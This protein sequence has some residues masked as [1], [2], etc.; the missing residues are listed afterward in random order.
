VGP[1]R[2]P[3]PTS[4]AADPPEDWEGGLQG[5]ENDENRAKAALGR[6][7]T[8]AKG[9]ATMSYIASEHPYAGHRDLTS[10]PVS[11]DRSLECERRALLALACRTVEEGL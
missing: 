10:D 4:G 8:S 11:P 3:V 5:R 7:S 1:Q 6:E 9:Q 2:A